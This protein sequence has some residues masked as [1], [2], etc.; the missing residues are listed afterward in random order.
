M[1]PPAVLKALRALPVHTKDKAAFNLVAI[2]QRS[3]APPPPPLQSSF[4]HDRFNTLYVKKR[5]L[6]VFI[7]VALRS[8]VLICAVLSPFPSLFEPMAG[9]LYVKEGRRLNGK[10]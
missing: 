2:I 5:R 8:W 3:A 6:D 1:T 10:G 4:Q 9:L 7:G